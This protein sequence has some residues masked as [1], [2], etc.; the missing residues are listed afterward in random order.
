[1]QIKNFVFLCKNNM[2]SSGNILPYF[3]YMKNNEKMEQLIDALPPESL[4]TVFPHTN[5]MNNMCNNRNVIPP[6]KNASYL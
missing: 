5:Q 2:L 6:P 1:M 4:P 3:N